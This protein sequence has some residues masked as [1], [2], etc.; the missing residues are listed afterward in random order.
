MHRGPERYEERLRIRE[1]VLLPVEGIHPATP[2]IRDE[3]KALGALEPSASV[4]VHSSLLAGRQTNLLY[5]PLPVEYHARKGRA[6]AVR[7]HEIDKE[8]R[9]K[10]DE[11]EHGIGSSTA[12]DV[13][14]PVSRSDVLL[15][16]HYI[17]GS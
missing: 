17:Y 14:R 2:Q 13:H 12:N 3:A 7:R 6:D 10:G 9:P 16:F 4:L 5:I 15:N 1:V 11:R 8:R